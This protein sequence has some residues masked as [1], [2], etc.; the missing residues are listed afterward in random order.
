MNKQLLVLVLELVASL[1]GFGLLWYATNWMAALGVFLLLF[2]NNLMK[3]RMLAKVLTPLIKMVE[4]INK[5][6]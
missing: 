5:P 1:T 6:K 3:S 4:L 2:G